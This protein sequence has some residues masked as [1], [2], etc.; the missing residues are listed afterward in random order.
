MKTEQSAATKRKKFLELGGKFE[1]GSWIAWKFVSD[2]YRSPTRRGNLLYKVGKTLVDKKKAEPDPLRSCAP[3]L[4]IHAGQPPKEGIERYC[5]SNKMILLELRVK[6]EDVVCIPD[7]ANKWKKGDWYTSGPKFRVQQV[8][9]V[10]A[11]KYDKVEVGGLGLIK[12][13][14]GYEFSE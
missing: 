1:G 2:K 7:E 6:P 9:I 14:S 8:E 11:Y 13:A 5:L 10:A 3:G 4:N 12:M